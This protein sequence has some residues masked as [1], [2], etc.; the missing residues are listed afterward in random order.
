MSES[1][2]GMVAQGTRW[3]I[4][5]FRVRFDSSPISCPD[6]LIEFIHTRSAYVAQTSLYGYLK[7]R[8][9]RN[10]V[11]IFKDSKYAPSLN[12]TKWSLYSA[13]LSDLVVYSVALMVRKTGM[14]LDDAAEFA[15]HCHDTCVSQTFDGPY[16]DA[17]RD[18]VIAAFA[19][20]C[21]NV[22]WANASIGESA[23]SLSPKTLAGSAPV[24]DEFK[25]LDRDIVMNSI[26][27]RWDDVRNQLRRRLDAESCSL[28][29]SGYT[30]RRR[31][32][33][34]QFMD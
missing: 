28:N 33:N 3:L 22:V 1:I 29:W 14:D 2:T 11:A 27:F 32:R 17:I 20:R 30:G 19:E 15:V 8:M 24:S 5:T 26:R 21:T 9:G 18:Q 10:Y 13:C 25:E 16:A 12:T 6:R 7:T 23:F 34:N 31:N 4:R